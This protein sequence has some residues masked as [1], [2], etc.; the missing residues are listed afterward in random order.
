MEEQSKGRE[1]RKAE[2]AQVERRDWGLCGG[3]GGVRAGRAMRSVRGCHQTDVA[4][5]NEGIHQFTIHTH[6]GA[7]RVGS[8]GLG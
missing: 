7:V 3:G 2:G 4:A 1:G 6:S 5:S 8:I